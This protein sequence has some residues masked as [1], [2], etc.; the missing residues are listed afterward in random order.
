[1]GG[2]PAQ[3]LVEL[4]GAL[5]GYEYGGVTEPVL[6]GDLDRLQ[7]TGADDVAG[8]MRPLERPRPRIE[9]SI[10]IE[11]AVVGGRSVLGPGLQDDLEG[12]LEPVARRRRADRVGPIFH[13]GAERE[14]DLEPAFR[15]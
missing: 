3:V 15:H 8:R 12:F 13:T 6:G 5:L 7:A 10:R 11:L 14:G 2:A 9:K 4:V 1:M